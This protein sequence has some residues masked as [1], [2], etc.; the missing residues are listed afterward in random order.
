MVQPFSVIVFWVMLFR[1]NYFEQWQGRVFPLVNH[2]ILRHFDIV[3][4]NIPDVLKHTSVIVLND[5]YAFFG[6]VGDFH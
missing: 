4:Q 6:Q 5:L 2:Q 3:C 1:Q